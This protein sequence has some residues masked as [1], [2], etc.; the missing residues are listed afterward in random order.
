MPRV[1]KY[2]EGGNIMPHD[3][4]HGPVKRESWIPAGNGG[5][6]SYKKIT[7]DLFPAGNRPQAPILELLK[8]RVTRE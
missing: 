6:G 7:K 8:P 3:H 5:A 4:P 2:H 1:R